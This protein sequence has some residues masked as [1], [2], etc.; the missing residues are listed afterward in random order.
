MDPYRPQSPQLSSYAPQSPDLSGR[1]QSPDLS[2]QPAQPAF[3][4]FNP[5][6]QQQSRF[7]GA[8]GGFH[9]GGGGGGG[10]GGITYPTSVPQQSYHQPYY[11][12]YQQQQHHQIMAAVKTEDG[13]Y[14][15]DA[16]PTK[17]PRGRPPGSGRNQLATSSSNGRPSSLQ[18]PAAPSQP[19]ADPTLGVELRTSFPVARIKRIMQADED[20]GKVAQVTPHVVSRALEL[21][22]IKLISA[23]A[24][25]ARGGSSSSN[26]PPSIK[27]EG[28][29]GGAAGSA[30]T[31]N[32]K[33]PKRILAQHMKK[34][35][36][37]DETLDFLADIADKVPDAP[38]KQSAAA[39]KKEAAS[40]PGSD[41]E[42]EAPVKPKRKGK[43][44]KD[45]ADD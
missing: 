22:M 39:A 6:Q 26:N 10:G 34:A 12:P 4:S 38:S 3:G 7:G 17:R 15:P 36:Q 18:Q 21:F 40:N 35:I 16:P 30:A 23:S 8:F 41:S 13:D 43:K 2:G 27:S 29:S 31:A 5:L 28:S 44:R 11:D 37:A 24:M 45:S 25:Q 32:N 20:V 14:F 33:G 42:G 19:S 9:G 1:P